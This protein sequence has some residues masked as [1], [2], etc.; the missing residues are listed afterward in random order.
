MMKD[1]IDSYWLATWQYVYVRRG[2]VGNIIIVHMIVTGI[3]ILLQVLW[4]IFKLNYA[5]LAYKIGGI[6]GLSIYLILI[7]TSVIPLIHPTCLA[8]L[9][10]RRIVLSRF[11]L[12]L[13]HVHEWKHSL[14]CIYFLL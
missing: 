7:S 8:L 12:I 1:A 9:P 11:F 10:R 4:I 14:S 2:S 5:E 13:H 3:I 6:S